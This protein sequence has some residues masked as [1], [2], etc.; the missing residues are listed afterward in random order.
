[1]TL[2]TKRSEKYLDML[3]FKIWSICGFTKFQTL[4]GSP[5]WLLSAKPCLVFHSIFTFIYLFIYLFIHLFI[6]LIYL[7]IDLFIYLL[8]YLFMYLFVS[9]F[10]YVFIYSF[11]YL[12]IYLVIYLFLFWCTV[13]YFS[14]IFPKI[15]T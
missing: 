15:M 10:I 8:R 6:Y 13:N 4:R 12:F 14:F 11:F 7:F 2:S 9:L 5:W 3:K 1:M